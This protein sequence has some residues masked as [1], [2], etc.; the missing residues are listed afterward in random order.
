MILKR[1]IAS[2]MIKA[3]LMTLLVLIVLTFV[4]TFI[5]EMD[6]I[7]KGEYRLLDAF[8]VALSTTP[9]LIYE[10]FPV[11]ALIGSL[12]GLGA[13]ANHGELVAIRAA[14][15]SLRQVVFS[16]INPGFILMLLVV[17]VGDIVAPI[18]E[19]YGQRLRLEKQNKQVT[20]HSRHGFWAKD[21]QSVVNI[22][23][24]RTGGRLKNITIYEFDEQNRLKLVTLA[25]EAKYVA[26]HWQMKGMRQ[27][28]ISDD[29]VVTRRLKQANLDSV[30]DPAMLDIA[31]VKPF[32]L[33]IWELYGYIETLRS[34]G[35]DA[36]NYA[37]AFWTKLATPVATVVMLILSV[38]FVLG[39]ARSVSTGQR[40]FAGALLGTLFY[41]FSRGF[42]FLVLVYEWPPIMVLLFPL[43]VF[44]FAML[45]FLQQSGLRSF[46]FRKPG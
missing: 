33:P 2:T 10:V 8:V 36:R 15:V 40:V 5:E 45:F 19:Q 35:Q 39:G 27:S 18:T 16:V 13:L 26:P 43:A 25:S 21:R 28:S 23:S 6:D 46:T 38:P 9:M 24:V 42:S 31:V 30:V 14:G 7:G 22:K 34:S 17:I 12:L 44:G 4:L 37:V 41:L 1:Y 32:Q 11:S 20:F 3:I 29:E